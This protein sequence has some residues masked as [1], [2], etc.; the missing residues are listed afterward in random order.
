M[1][2]IIRAVTNIPLEFAFVFAPILDAIRY[3]EC[4]VVI[5][6]LLHFSTSTADFSS[7]FVFEFVFSHWEKPNIVFI[8]IVKSLFDSA[9]LTTDET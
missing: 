7:T 8:R 6:I 3:C 1:L 5:K 9:L 4:T 2:K